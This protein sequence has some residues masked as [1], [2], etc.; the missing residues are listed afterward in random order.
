MCITSNQT[1]KV[2]LFKNITKLNL[3]VILSSI[4]IYVK[5][6]LIFS[7]KYLFVFCDSIFKKLLNI[8]LICLY[9]T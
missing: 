9:F 4:K 8:F 5:V 6:V 1:F 7:T 2:F 3:K